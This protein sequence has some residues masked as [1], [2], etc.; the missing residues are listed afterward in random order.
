MN[1]AEGGI[2]ARDDC[3]NTA[4]HRA[5]GMGLYGECVRLIEEKGSDFQIKN[6]CKLRPLELAV[7]VWEQYTAACHLQDYEKV[8]AYLEDVE[9]LKTGGLGPLVF[10]KDNYDKS[11]F[12]NVVGK[13][14]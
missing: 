4:L 12:V 14:E 10:I 9:V 7:N 11:G 13:L 3:G 6:N 2:D 5:A 8:I 1:I